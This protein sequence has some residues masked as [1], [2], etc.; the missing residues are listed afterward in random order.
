MKTTDEI[1]NEM[2]ASFAQRTGLEI[3]GGCD[4]AA[5]LYAV[6]AQV[7]SLLVQGEWVTRQC[8]PQTAEGEYLER[9]AQLRGLERKEATYAQGVVRFFVGESS[10]LDRTVG[11]GTVCMTAGLVRFETTREAAVKAGE[12]YVDVPVRALEPGSSGNILANTIVSMAV[13]PVGVRSCTNPAAFA[14][15]GDTETDEELRV[16]VMDTFRRLPNGANAAFYEQGALSFDQ[17]AAATVIPRSRGKGTVDVIAATLEGVPERE[18]LDELQAYFQSRREI[19]VDVL[20]RAPSLLPVNVAVKIKAQS[21]R[22][23]TALEQ[24]EEKLRGWFTGKRLGQ[25]VLLA[26]LGALVYECPGVENYQIVS[27]AADL[28]VTQEQLPVL[29][30]LTVEEMA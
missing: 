13:A 23:Q 18:L 19:A 15:G 5:R 25:A 7:Y 21:G 6:A 17:V 20:V 11:L 29:S 16:R 28:S 4:L 14:G 3:R 27:P 22:K 8:F 24:V 26:Q 12:T 2:L 30:S 1:F 9:H 10:G